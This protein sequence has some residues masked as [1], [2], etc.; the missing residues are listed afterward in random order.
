M[1]ACIYFDQVYDF[2]D[3]EVGFII[4][5][6]IFSHNPFDILLGLPSLATTEVLS[7]VAACPNLSNSVYFS[8][9]FI[10]Q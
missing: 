4:I 8:D 9:R 6:M 3:K 5:P 10:L 2:M 7:L 1:Y